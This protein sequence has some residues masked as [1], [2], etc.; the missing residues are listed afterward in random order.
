MAYEQHMAYGLLYHM[1]RV[2][3]ASWN[4]NIPTSTLYI[5]TIE[6]LK[7]IDKYIYNS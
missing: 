5:Y 3:S 2:L 7:H 1:A 6:T 4:H